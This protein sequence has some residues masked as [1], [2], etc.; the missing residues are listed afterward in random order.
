MPRGY[1]RGDSFQAR[2]APPPSG[3]PCG[4]PAAGIQLPPL[5]ARIARADPAAGGLRA[6]SLVGEGVGHRRRQPAAG[7]VGQA[8]ARHQ[9]PGP[10][11][12]LPD[13]RRDAAVGRARPRRHR[14]RRRVR[15]GARHRPADRRPPR[16]PGHHLGHQRRGR[17]PRAAA[18]AVLRGDLRYRRARARCSRSGSPPPPR[19]PAWCGPCPPRSRAS[20]TSRRHGSPASPGSGC[21]PGT[22]CRTSASPSSSTPPSPPATRCCPSRACP[23]S[24]SASRL[25]PTTGASCSTTACRASTPG[26]PPPLPPASRSCV[27]GLAFNLFGEALAVGLGV[28]APRI[29]RLRSALAAAAAKVSG[30]RARTIIPNGSG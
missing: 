20:T 13:P 6:R 30:A 14:D 23:S 5:A 19:S 4:T 7:P 11:R 29:G 1:P 28:S 15:P 16:G 27:A 9:R 21:S 3:V 12:L 17:V 22:S 18:R 26:P 10:G 24:A 2:G 8:L 25:P